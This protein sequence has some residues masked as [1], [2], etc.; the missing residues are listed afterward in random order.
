[1][2]AGFTVEEIGHVTKIDR[3]FLAAASVNAGLSD[4]TA[5]RLGSSGGAKSL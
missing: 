4:A 3:W 1:M 2:R 5:L